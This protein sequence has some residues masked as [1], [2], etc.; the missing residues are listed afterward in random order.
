MKKSAMNLSL[1]LAVISIS[2]VFLA[3]AFPA[4]ASE[5][6]D[7]LREALSRQTGGEIMYV[8]EGSSGASAALQT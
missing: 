3:D 4:S 2:L 8:S 6:A 5:L 7:S 1:K